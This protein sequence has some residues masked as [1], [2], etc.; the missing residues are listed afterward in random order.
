MVIIPII[1]LFI[2]GVII[3]KF[4][5]KPRTPAFNVASLSLLTSVVVIEISF[6]VL[7]VFLNNPFSNVVAYPIATIFVTFTAYYIVKQILEKET[8]L[9]QQINST[10][11]IVR[12]QT[13]KLRTQASALQDVLNAS[14]EVSINVSNM[15]SE[16][17][18]SAEEVNSSA[19]EISAST[20][21]F[22]ASSKSQVESLAIINNK[23]KDLMKQ[24]EMILG[25]TEAIKRIMDLIRTI[26]DQTNLLALNA[27]IEAG[28]AGKY[29]R[30]F[31]VVAEEV[32]KLAEESKNAVASSN[33]E[34]NEIVERIQSQ[35]TLVTN[36]TSDI[37]NLKNSGEENARTASDISAAT[38]EQTSAMEEVSATSG[39]LSSLVDS[40]RETLSE[41]ENISSKGAITK[42]GT[43]SK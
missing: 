31:T 20:E 21:E 29:G 26:S 2:L 43:I 17:A 23:A 16:L 38:E 40:L 39:R 10:D 24:S 41:Y 25:S 34:I 42:G 4:K 11:N 7:G 37:N 35:D 30:G 15:A 3:Y 27:S 33:K 22:A 6:I 8:L 5:L 18:S 19:E 32:R 1:H 12:Q 14:S 13:S 28:R 36:I 9:K